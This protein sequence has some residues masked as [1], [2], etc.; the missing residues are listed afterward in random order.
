MN[1]QKPAGDVPGIRHVRGVLGLDRGKDPAR[2][3]ATTTP[4]VRA[5]NK[6]A[7]ATPTY[8]AASVDLTLNRVG[9]GAVAGESRNE[10]AIG[11]ALNAS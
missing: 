7:A 4:T 11:N 1:P 10:Q 3:P 6:A 8:N 5:P 2:A 9:F